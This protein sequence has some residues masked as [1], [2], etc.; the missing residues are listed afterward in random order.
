MS[1]VDGS[2]SNL[3]ICFSTISRALRRRSNRSADTLSGTEKSLPPSAAECHSAPYP[4][5]F[6]VNRLPQKRLGCRNHQRVLRIEADH[7]VT[8][9][10]HRRHP[11]AWPGAEAASSEIRHTHVDLDR[12]DVQA[13][14]AWILFLGR[15]SDYS[16][17]SILQTTVWAVFMPLNLDTISSFHVRSYRSS[18]VGQVLEVS[19][20][21]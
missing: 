5:I 16:P 15:R 14:R 2:A 12:I 4:A 19:P 6:L 20:D 10:D 13:I 17:K 1:S 7:Q 21:F 3:R 18:R 11:P 8:S 9:R